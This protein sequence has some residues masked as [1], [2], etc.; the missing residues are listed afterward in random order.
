MTVYSVQPMEGKELS[1]GE[2]LLPMIEFAYNVHLIRFRKE[3]QYGPCAIISGDGA[4]ELR[5]HGLPLPRLVL[6]KV[7]PISGWAE[8]ILEAESE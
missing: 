4:I 6:R 8:A 7:S 3:G 5:R 1:A 2:V